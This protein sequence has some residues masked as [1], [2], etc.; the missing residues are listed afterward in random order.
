MEEP[1]SPG[2]RGVRVEGRPPELSRAGGGRV[3]SALRSAGCGWTGLLVWARPGQARG[4]AGPSRAS[5]LSA[6]AEPEPARARGEEA[7]AERVPVLY[8]TLLAVR[9]NET[10]L[11]ASVTSLSPHCRTAAPPRY[12]TQGRILHAHGTTAVVD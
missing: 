10:L 4:E 8:S 7:A 3:R 11:A 6:A 5:V 1:S 12:T 2:R 9:R